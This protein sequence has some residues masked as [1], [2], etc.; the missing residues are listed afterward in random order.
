MSGTVCRTFDLVGANVYTLAELVKF[1]G[2][3][4]KKSSFVIPIPRALGY[5]QAYMLEFMP[6]PTLMSRD[7]LASMQQDNVLPM[8]AENALQKTF[9]ITPQPLEVLLQ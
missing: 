4:V 9:G 2:A 3:K 6:G 8:G 7:N 1:A 5:L